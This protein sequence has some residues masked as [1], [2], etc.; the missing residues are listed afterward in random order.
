MA[1]RKPYEPKDFGPR[2]KTQL[3][4]YERDPKAKPEDEDEEAKKPLLKKAAE[5][6]GQSPDVR[7]IIFLLIRYLRLIF[8]ITHYN[9]VIEF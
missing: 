3:E 2:E 1:D 9:F 7:L 6:V 8:R 4:T 5:T